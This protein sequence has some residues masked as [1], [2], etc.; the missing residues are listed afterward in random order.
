MARKPFAQIHL[1][2]A[3]VLLPII[4]YQML[5]FSAE[6]EIMI[7]RACVVLS[8]LEFYYSIYVISKQYLEYANIPFLYLKEETKQ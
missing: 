1:Q 3:Y 4:G 6:I 5:G 2:Y 8:F 7:T